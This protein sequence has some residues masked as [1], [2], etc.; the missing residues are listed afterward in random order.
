MDLSYVE[1]VRKGLLEQRS[2]L[3]GLALFCMAG[4]LLIVLKNARMER[5]SNLHRLS[6]GAVAASGQT[7]QGN[8]ASG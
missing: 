7:V 2:L 4:T 6:Q 5:A 8:Q 3:L 1:H